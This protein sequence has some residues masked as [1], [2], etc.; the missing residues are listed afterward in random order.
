MSTPDA[1]GAKFARIWT[2]LAASVRAVLLLGLF[3]GLVGVW[4]FGPAEE[5]HAMD[6]FAILLFCLSPLLIWITVEPE[7]PASKL[8]RPFARCALGWRFPFLAGGASGVVLFV[9]F[10]AVAVGGYVLWLRFVSDQ[11]CWFA[12]DDPMQLAMG[13]MYASVYV[14]LP[15][16]LL[17]P[18]WRRPWTIPL[19]YLAAVVVAYY[20]LPGLFPVGG[21]HADRFSELG[22][23][24][25]M[26][27]MASGRDGSIVH[28]ARADF[29]LLC[30]LAAL[31]V[32]VNV[33]RVVRR[34]RELVRAAAGAAPAD[35]ADRA[36][37]ADRAEHADTR[38]QGLPGTE[39]A[40]R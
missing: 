26:I 10:F 38:T 27:G 4:T 16:G 30:A 25:H 1:D 34:R 5:E 19:A 36:D 35:S 40:A 22:N 2:A 13:A 29:A 23:P 33:P 11:R 6:S 14:L 21:N 24:L 8:V 12:D 37:R 31:G 32:L 3:A 15:V 7:P 20:L 18:L 39:Q 28:Y 17:A 9:L